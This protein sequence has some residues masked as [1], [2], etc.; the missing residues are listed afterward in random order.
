MRRS[1]FGILAFG[2]IQFGR[3]RRSFYSAIATELRADCRGNDI[4]ETGSDAAE[5]WLESGQ[6]SAAD[7]EIHFDCHPDSCNDDLPARVGG[8]GGGVEDVLPSNADCGGVS[9]QSMINL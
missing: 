5:Q 8:L 7:G 1:L 3:L 2:P 6:A 4:S 9:W